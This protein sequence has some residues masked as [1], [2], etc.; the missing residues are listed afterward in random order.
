MTVFIKCRASTVL[1]DILRSDEL[2]WDED[3]GD[4]GRGCFQQD[5]PP[6]SLC[7][8]LFLTLIVI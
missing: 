4:D 1:L 8:Q 5:I 6:D 7:L 3:D 2:L